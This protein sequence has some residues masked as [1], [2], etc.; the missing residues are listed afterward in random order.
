MPQY[1]RRGFAAHLA[2]PAWGLFLM[3]LVA[4]AATGAAEVPAPAIRP[5]DSVPAA[6]KE[7]KIDWKGSWDETLAANL[8]PGKNWQKTLEGDESLRQAAPVIVRLREISLLEAMIAKFP[9]P[10]AKRQQAY[11]TIAQDYAGLGDRTRA[12]QWM[13]RLIGD[14]PA[15]KPLA[16]EAL[17]HILT[18]AQ[19]FQTL[20]DPLG[21]A[22]YANS[23][24]ESLVKASALPP[25][26]PSVVLSREQLCNA[27]RYEQKPEAARRFLDSLKPAEGTQKW[28]LT[29]RAQL[30]LAAGHL[31]Q[32][33]ALYAKAGNEPYAKQLRESLGQGAPDVEIAPPAGL[34]E[35]LERL[36]GALRLTGVRALQNVEAVQDVL[37]RAADS[38][39]IQ[40]VDDS[41][42]AS[43][44]VVL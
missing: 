40:T 10:A 22:Q 5:L 42:Q 17:A 14:Y 30:M 31:P 18:Y 39:A 9:E 2:R 44:S 36:D 38:G 4:G 35:R 12:G 15:Q 3:A 29:A 13:Q 8:D 34:V 11:V 33:A 37:T 1:V 7:L 24:F 20:P 43:S 41:L 21:W 23:G 26:H 6:W 19:P 27:L 16:A 25:N 32:A 28:W